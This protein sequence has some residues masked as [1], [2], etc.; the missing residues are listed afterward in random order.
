MK[1]KTQLKRAV[2]R[3]KAAVEAAKAVSKKLEEEK[4]RPTSGE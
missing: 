1:T 3:H 2:A 4:K